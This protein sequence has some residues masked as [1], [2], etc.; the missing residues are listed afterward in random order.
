MQMNVT[1]PMHIHSLDGAM[2]EATIV[3]MVG[4]NAYIAEYNGK[5]CSAIYNPFADSDSNRRIAWNG[6][7][8]S[9]PIS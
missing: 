6:T 9:I 2:R 8:R 5:R 7:V 4:E 1:E 3:E